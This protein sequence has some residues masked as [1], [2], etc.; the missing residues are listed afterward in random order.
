MHSPSIKPEFITRETAPWLCCLRYQACFV[1]ASWKDFFSNFAGS[2]LQDM[3]F[4]RFQHKLKTFLLGSL[5]TTAHRDC[6][7]FW[8]IE[9]VLLTYLLM[10]RYVAWFLTELHFICVFSISDYI[11]CINIILMPLFSSPSVC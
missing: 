2:I 1:A 6:L 8:A 3:N 4:A 9:I 7:L 11:D 10:L 5:S